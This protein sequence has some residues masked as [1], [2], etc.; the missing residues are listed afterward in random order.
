V[1]ADGIEDRIDDIND[2]L[3]E[4]IERIEGLRRFG[5]T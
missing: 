3:D 2:G 4:L 1:P 5:P